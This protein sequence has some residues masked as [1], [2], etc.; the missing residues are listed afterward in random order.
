MLREA[1]SNESVEGRRQSASTG[2]AGDAEDGGDD[3]IEAFRSSLLVV[4]VRRPPA[5]PPDIVVA[6]E[7]W[8]LLK[9]ERFEEDLDSEGTAGRGGRGGNLGP[10]VAVS[11]LVFLIKSITLRA[12]PLVAV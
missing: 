7:V 8:L 10:W 2:T 3:C 4:I 9:S 6:R 12:R 5:P 11:T 1:G